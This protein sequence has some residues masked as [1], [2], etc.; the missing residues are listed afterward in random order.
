MVFK[1][2]QPSSK[3]GLIRKLSSTCACAQ[4]SDVFGLLVNNETVVNTV[5]EVKPHFES[6]P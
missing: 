3:I 6:A 2:I 5:L 1:F 4:L